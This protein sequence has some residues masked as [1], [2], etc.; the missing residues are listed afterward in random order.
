MFI[1]RTTLRLKVYGTHFTQ[2]SSAV[3][4]MR[5]WLPTTAIV[6]QV[7]AAL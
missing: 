6:L 1:H 5:K 2:W 3:D 7:I 4:L